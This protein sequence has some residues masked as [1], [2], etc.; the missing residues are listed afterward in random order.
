VSLLTFLAYPGTIS[1]RSDT[2][3]AV[4]ED[5][6]NSLY[7]AGFRRILVMNGHGGNDGARVAWPKYPIVLPDL[8]LSWYAWW[9]SHSVEAVGRKHEIKLYHAGWLEAFPFTRVADLPPGEKAPPAVKGIMNAAEAR[10]LYG[11]GVF[12]GAYQVDQHIM[13]EI[14]DAALQDVLYMLEF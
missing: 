11:D 7:Q 2:F 8:K 14:F 6:L 12:G 5:I 10:Q 1:L 13:D 4:V 3:L 9:Q